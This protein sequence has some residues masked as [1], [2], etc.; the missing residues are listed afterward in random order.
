[1]ID[2]VV[3][4]HS[5]TDEPWFAHSNFVRRSRLTPCKPDETWSVLDRITR[6]VSKSLTGA[7][8]TRM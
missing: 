1:M 7:V 8:V 2:S 3:K 6:C 5:S 4:I